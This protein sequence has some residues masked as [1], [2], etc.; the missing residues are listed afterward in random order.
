M[1]LR[2]SDNNDQNAEDIQ[3]TSGLE[4]P[5]RTQR[6][7][8]V[9]MTQVE[10]EERVAEAAR[11]LFQNTTSSST[12]NRANVATPTRS[13]RGSLSEEAIPAR[14]T[15]AAPSTHGLTSNPTLEAVLEYKRLK[16]D[17]VLTTTS[18]IEQIKQNQIS[19]TTVGSNK[20]FK[21]LDSNASRDWT[22][23]NGSRHPPLTNSDAP[24]SIGIFGAHNIGES[25]RNIQLYSRRRCYALVS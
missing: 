3:T 15:S 8:M 19:T 7:R 5:G 6:P 4:T 2:S 25:R 14:Q 13:Q 20:R 10:F 1:N 12:T 11:D 22:L 23:P 24:E 18:E 16:L 17:L 21:A 9:T